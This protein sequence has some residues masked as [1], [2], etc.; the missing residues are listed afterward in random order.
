M[1]FA[2]KDELKEAI[3]EYAIVQ[4]RNVK[5]IDRDEQTFA[6]K[7]L[8]LE[9]KKSPEWDVGAFQ[10]EVLEKYHMNVSRHQIYRAKSLSKVIIEGSYVEQYARL[11]DYAEE[12]KKVN[13][14]STEGHNKTR[15]ANQGAAHALPNQPNQGTFGSST[16][17]GAAQAQPNQP[18][19]SRGKRRGKGTTTGRGK[20][21]DRGQMPNGRGNVD[22][23]FC[24]SSLTNGPR[25]LSYLALFSGNSLI[26]AYG[27]GTI[28]VPTGLTQLDLPTRVRRHFAFSLHFQNRACNGEGDGWSLLSDG[29]LPFTHEF[30]LVLAL[31][32]C[33]TCLKSYQ[34]AFNSIDVGW[35]KHFGTGLSFKAPQVALKLTFLEPSMGPVIACFLPYHNLLTC[36][37]G[38][39]KFSFIPI[40]LIL[41]PIT[42]IGPRVNLGLAPW[43]FGPQQNVGNG[44]TEMPNKPSSSQPLFYTGA[45]SSSSQPPNI[46]D[47]K[48]FKYLAKRFKSSAKKLRPWMF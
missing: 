6:I 11:W 42:Y 34:R 14:G 41:H 40:E 4:G 18:N 44:T 21:N 30:L 23:V 36:V 19:P 3:R 26:K 5:L 31:T 46:A 43:I 10:S 2:K 16:V 38:S 39:Y 47:I 28:V 15:H 20:G 29:Y 48:R 25:L 12:L 8:S 1:Q 17:Q 24:S 33:L 45:T 22:G 13:K 37:G 32:L 27:K 9:H 35:A 7:T